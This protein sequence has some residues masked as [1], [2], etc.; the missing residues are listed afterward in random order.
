MSER[1]ERVPGRVHRFRLAAPRPRLVSGDPTVRCSE[2]WPQSSREL[3]TVPDQCSVSLF[4]CH[5]GGFCDARHLRRTRAHGYP[6]SLIAHVKRSSALMILVTG[7]TGNMGL[8]LMRRLA[9]S[10][11]DIRA[12]TRDERR[13]RALLPPGTQIEEGDLAQ[14]DFL[15]KALRD[16]DKLFLFLEAGDPAR[17]LEVASDVGVPYVVLVTSLLAET[18]PRSF[19]GQLALGTEQLMWESGFSGTVLRPW[20]YASNTLAWAREIQSGDVVRKPSAGL[21]SPVIDPADVAAVAALALLED[22]HDG[23]TYALTGPAELTAQDK[24]AALSAALGR[25]V[26]FEENGEPELLAKIRNAP[27]EVAEEFGVCFMES[28]GVLSTVEDVTG[29]RPRAFS[30]WALEH[31][32]AFK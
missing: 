18:R 1:G 7:A 10:G 15:E 2:W 12:T 6:Y 30:E 27:E 13:A 22:G 8:P 26:T 11:A 3:T 23:R 17:V 25:E 4:P 9:G 29:R 5:A 21:P 16:V 24:V 32:A 14:P 28:P 19:V 31:S 20:E